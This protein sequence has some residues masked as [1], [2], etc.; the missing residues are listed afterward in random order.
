MRGNA[1]QGFLVIHDPP[2]SLHSSPHAQDPYIPLSTPKLSPGSSSP[3]WP[4]MFAPV[5]DPVQPS[6]PGLH[7]ILTTYCVLPLLYCD[8]QHTSLP[9]KPWRTTYGAHAMPSPALVGISSSSSVQTS[10]PPLHCWWSLC[11]L[12]W[13]MLRITS[14][15]ISLML[16]VTPHILIACN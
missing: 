9:S 13:H 10:L 1:A 12:Q 4:S 16:F 5:C 7:A 8:L 11:H 14:R 15:P 6:M 2:D 3:A